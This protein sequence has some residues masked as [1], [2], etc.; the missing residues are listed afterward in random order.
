MNIKKYNRFKINVYNYNRQIKLYLRMVNERVKP[1][2]WN[3]NFIFDQKYTTQ[4]LHKLHRLMHSN[5]K[6]TINKMEISCQL[7]PELS[8][9]MTDRIYNILRCFSEKKIAKL[10]C[11]EHHFFKDNAPPMDIFICQLNVELPK[12]M[13]K[14]QLGYYPD[15]FYM[16]PNLGFLKLE[17]LNNIIWH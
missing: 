7:G 4:E 3:V 10:T 11:H 15:K 12:T 17:S 14:L 5:H 8:E 6:K 1:D 2:N 9:D 16:L 13:S